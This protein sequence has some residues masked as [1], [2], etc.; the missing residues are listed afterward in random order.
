MPNFT[1]ITGLA[2]VASAMAASMLLLPRVTRLAKNRQAIVTGTVFVVM[3]IPFDGFPLAAY[4]RGATGDLSITS[5]VLLW[6][7]LS[8]P[9]SVCGTE[10]LNHRHVLLALIAL[11][12]LAF[13][14]MA[15]GFGEFD[16]YRLGYGSWQMVTALLLA[17][18]LAWLWKHHQFA[19]CVGF[20]TLAWAIGWYE[21]DNLWDYLLDPFVSIYAL[22]AIM[23]NTGKFLMKLPRKKLNKPDFGRT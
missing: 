4:M 23:M 17:A 18:L 14:P 2:S 5:M 16:P 11:A 22:A 7:A 8:R 21:S 1:D 19:L 12:A 10:D 3:L 15:L 9:W 6:Y 20:A 13:Y